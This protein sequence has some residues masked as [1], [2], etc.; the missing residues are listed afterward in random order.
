MPPGSP[1]LNFENVWTETSQSQGL[2]HSLNIFLTCLVSPYGL[3]P[4]KSAI[5]ERWLKAR[6]LCDASFRDGT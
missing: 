1:E 3:G 6:H 2:N 5:S 4:P